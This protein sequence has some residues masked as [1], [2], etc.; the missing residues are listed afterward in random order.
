[1]QNFRMFLIKW[2]SLLLLLF[3]G[4]GLN[5]SQGN[6]EKQ[7]SETIVLSIPSCHG[8]EAAYINTYR[9]IHPYKRQSSMLYFI[10]LWC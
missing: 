4:P 3:L 1:M 7:H 5:F 9:P 2:S 6:F 10:A 8:L